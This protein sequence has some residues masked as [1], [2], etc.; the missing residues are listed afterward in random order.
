MD[1]L[2]LAR[3]APLWDA[4]LRGAVFAGLRPA[5]G[6]HELVFDRA[7][8]GPRPARRL[9]FFVRLAPPVWAWLEDAAR[10][11]SSDWTFRLPE[12]A[13]VTAVAAPAMDRR[14]VLELE[15]PAGGP[16]AIHLELWAPGNVIAEVP[17]V[18]ILWCAR[19]RPPSTHRAALA[20]GAVYAPPARTE[21][22]D[23]A[24][25]SPALLEAWFAGVEP[26]RRALVLARQVAGLPKGLLDVLVPTLPAELLAQPLDDAALARALAAWTR[27]TY[28][29]DR[30]FG[31]AWD[32]P[33][34][35]ATLVTR[36]LEGGAP[37]VRT[38]GPFEVWD[39]AA[40]E[41]A[42]ALPAPLDA[43]ALAAA[44][45]DVK[46]LVRTEGAVAR[47]LE[48]ARTAPEARREADALAA[49]LP[50]VTRGASSV[51]LP[52]PAEPERT[53][54]IALDPTM[55]PH[56]NLD[57][58]YKR[59]GKLERALEQAPARLAAV[60]AELERARE[61]VAALERGEGDS[62]P[63]RE[64]SPGTVRRP[65]GPPSAEP[66]RKGAVPSVL[67]PR[68]YKTREGW[69]VW[70][71]KNNQGNDHLTHRLARPEDVWMHVHGAAGSHVV[72]RRGRGPNEPSKA[73][74][75]EV[76]AWAAFYS[77][78]R[79][80]G[81]VP[82]TVTEKKYVRKPRKAPAGLAE[83][84]R[85]KTVF[86]KPAEPPDDARVGNGEE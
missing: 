58:L 76:A 79:N 33:S 70:I 81:T 82:V 72:I 56:E 6:G 55:K 26:E 19:T 43:D 31:A 4:A 50:R 44:R 52:D 40:R 83:V 67:E 15:G 38:I 48:Q 35:G 46:R 17:G 34:A 47:D 59:A 65:K 1:P 62:T 22:A 45:A 25:V 29:G 60:R 85:S 77:Q 51:D 28:G 23:P 21:I 20:P 30:V 66:R 3:L 78:A 39:D 10:G 42:R 61:R 69:E 54:T 16:F 37:A 14:L 27:A 8:D 80:A 32:V 75:Q 36:A 63:S 41:L 11:G 7:P 9:A 53:L 5:P 49:F 64:L 2:V 68:R 86:A 24:S 12:G 74:L 73:T 13:R 18:R 71:G 57:R 84:T